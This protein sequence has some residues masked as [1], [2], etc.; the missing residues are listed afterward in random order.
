MSMRFSSGRMVYI[1]TGK[2]LTV[3]TNGGEKVWTK[4]FSSVDEAREEFLA[5][6]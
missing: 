1:L 4:F 5:L 3:Y 6:V 2:V